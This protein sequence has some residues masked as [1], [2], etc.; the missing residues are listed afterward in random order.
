MGGCGDI[1]FFVP[2]FLPSSSPSPSHLYSLAIQLRYLFIVASSQG[3]NMLYIFAMYLIEIN[4][5]PFH[6][7]S[8]FWEQALNEMLNPKYTNL[9]HPVAFCITN[10]PSSCEKEKDQIL[11][12]VP[13]FFYP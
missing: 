7:S 1:L 8:Q 4:I 9:L 5:H 2:A 3:Q 10:S 6:Y 11:S 13:D 12:L